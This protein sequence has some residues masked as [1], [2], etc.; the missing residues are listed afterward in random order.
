MRSP[1]AG[2]STCGIRASASTLKV[3]SVG[4][5]W[6]HYRYKVFDTVVPLRNMIWKS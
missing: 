4:T 5:D 2:T 6:K 3:D 1:I